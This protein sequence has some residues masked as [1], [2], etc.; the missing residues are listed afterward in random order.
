MHL[1]RANA[2]ANHLIEGRQPLLMNHKYISHGILS[3]S[4][5][6]SLSTS[7]WGGDVDTYW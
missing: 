6:T 4:K 3:K 7:E 1:Q 5:Q 2:A